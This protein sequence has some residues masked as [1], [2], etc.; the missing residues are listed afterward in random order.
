MGRPWPFQVT[1][2]GTVVR[3]DDVRSFPASD[4]REHTDEFLSRTISALQGHLGLMFHRI[5][6]T[7]AVRIRLDVEDLDDGTGVLSEVVALDPFAHPGSP[8]GWPKDLVADVNGSRLTLHCHLWPGRSNL[9]QYRLPGGAESR[10]GL[11]FYRRGRLLDAGGWEGI[12]APDRKLQLARV[13]VDIDGDLAGMFIMNPE[14]SRVITGTEFARAVSAARAGDGTSI[15]DYLKA[16]EDTWVRSNQRTSI[17]TA[18]IPPGRGLHPKISR[19]IRE[20]LPQLHVE[21][22]S[23]QWRPFTTDDLFDVDRAAN[24]L[25]L[26]QLYRR[27]LLGGR[28]GGLNDVP[29]IK[30]LLFLLTQQVFQGSHLGARDKDNVELWQEILTAAAKAE[31]STF[32]NRT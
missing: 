11:Y 5:L 4:D 20:E 25:W 32:E 22:L 10:Q 16:A 29:V 15:N 7:G 2:H 17:R 23:I 26:N 21:P 19:E 14:K 27:A 9:P 1:E 3:W 18:V 31:R 13:A 30:A 6:T 28:R 8:H 12:H 24:T